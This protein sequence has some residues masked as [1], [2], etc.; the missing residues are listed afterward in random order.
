MTSKLFPI[1]V[2]VL[3]GSL[4]SSEAQTNRQSEKLIKIWEN[5]DYRVPV[6]QE[7][8]NRAPSFTITSGEQWNQVSRG[9]RLDISDLMQGVQFLRTNAVVARLYRANG[10]IVEPTLEG[11]E[12]L[13]MPVSTSWSAV[14]PDGTFALG[15]M[16]YFPWGTN[17]LEEAWIKVTVGPERYWLEIPYGFDRNPADPL[18]PGISEG[19]PQFIPVMNPLT[20]HDHV[21][22]WQDVRYTLENTADVRELSLIQSNPSLAESKVELREFNKAV[23]LYSPH[24][25]VRILQV[26]G[27]AVNG[28]CVDIHLSDGYRTDTF[29]IGELA[30]SLRC[31]G[32]IEVRIADQTYRVATPSSLYKNTH[33]HAS[34]PAAI[35]FL[36]ALRTGMT[37]HQTERISANYTF[38]RKLTSASGTNHCY[39]Y[40]FTPGGDEATIQFDKSDRLV[41]WK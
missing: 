33:G 28:R 12:T 10:E 36:S 2:L 19:P 16:T 20:E 21:I 30:D 8:L 27:S 11:K 25:N 31:W 34:K 6:F 14:L 40:A 29:Q 41:S 18:P 15:V 17:A 39:Q 7:E 9:L 3:S 32:Q 13:N 23:D 38:T 24:M 1:L 4:F 26:D 35:G 37:L 22:C 5:I